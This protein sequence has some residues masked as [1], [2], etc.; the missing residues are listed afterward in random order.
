MPWICVYWR[1]Q[2]CGSGKVLPC[3]ASSCVSVAGTP[4]R[5]TCIEDGQWRGWAPTCTRSVVPPGGGGWWGGSCGPLRRMLEIPKPNSKVMG[6]WPE[7][8][9]QRVDC[10]NASCSATVY[11]A[12]VDVSGCRGTSV[13]GTCYVTCSYGYTGTPSVYSCTRRTC[14]GGATWSGRPPTCIS[15]LC[16]LPLIP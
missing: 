8:E 4:G 7:Y 13:G 5:Y 15:M 9:T 14:R 1:L 2:T 12:N 3:L 6:V 16:G 10:M 11:A